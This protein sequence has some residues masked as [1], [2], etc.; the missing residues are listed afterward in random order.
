MASSSRGKFPPKFNG[1]I[2]N[3]GGDLRTW[4][5]Q[6]WFAN[7]AAIT[8][9]SRHRPLELMDPVF[10]M[11]TGM[12]EASAVAARQQ[13]GSQGIYIPET[14]YF[15]GLEKLPDDIAA[16]MRELYLAA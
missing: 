12:H 8:R 15:D 6:H 11:Y 5:A 14:T 3:T 16:E 9:R 1:M 13:W 2:W 10:D 7:R 4:G